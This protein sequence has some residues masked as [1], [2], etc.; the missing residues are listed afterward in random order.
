MMQ[1]RILLTESFPP[2]ADSRRTLVICALCT[3]VNHLGGLS[4]PRKSVGRLTGRPDKTIVVY[5]A[6]E[7][8]K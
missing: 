6:R 3:L 5:R 2:A 1:F 8:T 7:A 4:L